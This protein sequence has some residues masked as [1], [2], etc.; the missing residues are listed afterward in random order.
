MQLQ[1]RS[2]DHWKNGRE[3]WVVG[4]RQGFVKTLPAQDCFR[5]ELR[6]AFGVGDVSLCGCDYRGVAFVERKLKK[7]RD[8]VVGLKMLRGIPP[9]CGAVDAD[10][11]PH[12]RALVPGRA[13]SPPD[14]GAILAPLHATP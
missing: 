7:R 3:L 1:T 13:V 11:G 6:P 14:A 2:A 10:F 5:C 4:R 8:V 9:V 12:G